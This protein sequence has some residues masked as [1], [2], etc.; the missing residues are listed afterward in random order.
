MLKNYLAV[1]L[2]NFWRNK[3]VSFIH[4]A[5][6]SIGLSCCMLIL[7]YVFDDWSF[8]RFHKHHNSIYQITMQILNPDGSFRASVGQTGTVYVPSFQRAIPE[9]I[10]YTRICNYDF[11]LK[12]DAEVYRQHIHFADPNFFSVFTFPVLSGDPNTALADLHG[13]V[14]TEESA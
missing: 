2:R 3:T 9:I 11:V 13:M 5:S 14:L 8:D 7:L 10:A 4:I 12:K 1:A 6:L